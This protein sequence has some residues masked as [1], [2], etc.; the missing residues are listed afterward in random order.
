MQFTLTS[1]IWVLGRGG[2]GICT[3]TMPPNARALAPGQ[4]WYIYLCIETFVHFLLQPQMFSVSCYY[5]FRGLEISSEKFSKQAKKK[6]QTSHS[7]IKNIKHNLNLP[8]GFSARKWQS[9]NFCSICVLHTELRVAPTMLVL[10][11]I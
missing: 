4:L 9:Q 5:G 3:K 8:L 7:N 2:P 10:Y 11:A 1:D 6:R